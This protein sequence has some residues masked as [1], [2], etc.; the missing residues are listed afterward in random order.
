MAY[1]CQRDLNTFSSKIDLIFAAYPNWSPAPGKRSHLYEHLK[2]YLELQNI[3]DLMREREWVEV[4]CKFLSG[5][6]IVQ[7]LVIQLKPTV[8][9]TRTISI[10]KQFV[11]DQLLIFLEEGVGIECY[12]QEDQIRYI[13]PQLQSAFSEHCGFLFNL[14]QNASSLTR[15]LQRFNYSTLTLMQDHRLGRAK[16]LL[17]DDLDSLF[18][19]LNA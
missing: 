14:N 5:D 8:E 18:L 3:K 2:E 15:S 19:I 16:Q 7:E 1:F 10:Q 12:K 9:A 4:Y 13:L 6:T 17:Q 11:Y